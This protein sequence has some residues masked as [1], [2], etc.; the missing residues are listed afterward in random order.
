MSFAFQIIILIIV[1]NKF[2]HKQFNIMKEEYKR[3]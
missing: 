2:L 3:G 1:L